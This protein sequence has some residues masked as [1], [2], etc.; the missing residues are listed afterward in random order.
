M[1]IVVPVD[2]CI[3]RYYRG[4]AVVDEDAS[5]EEI[6]EEMQRRILEDNEEDVLEPDPDLDIEEHDIEFMVPKPDESW[7]EEE[8]IEITEIL[9]KINEGRYF[10]KG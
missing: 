8:T 10:E 3:R 4:Y 2:V 9:K 6:R 5:L 1:K 7:T